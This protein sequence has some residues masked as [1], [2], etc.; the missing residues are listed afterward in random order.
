MILELILLA[1]GLCGLVYWR[2]QTKS[3][4]W[5]KLGIR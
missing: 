5:T 1:A 3:R 4:L 2:Y